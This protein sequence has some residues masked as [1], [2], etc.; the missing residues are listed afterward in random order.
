MEDLWP[1]DTTFGEF[2][3]I[4][5]PK[6]LRKQASWI[7]PSR[8]TFFSIQW[9]FPKNWQY[10]AVEPRGS[11]PPRVILDPPVNKFL[12]TVIET[13]VIQNLWRQIRSVQVS[14]KNRRSFD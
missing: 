10:M 7:L 1:L 13:F 5:T 3:K 14:F 2:F 8:N 6:I 11:A 12:T 4:W 9:G